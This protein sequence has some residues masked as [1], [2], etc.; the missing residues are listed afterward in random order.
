[1]AGTAAIIGS[2]IVGGASALALQ[3]AGF[4]VTLIDPMREPSG[5]SWGNAGHIATEQVE[6]L[7]SRAV[8]RSVPERL[9][10]NGGALDFRGRDIDRWLP[11]SLRW[12]AATSPARFAKGKAALSSL[13]ANA[14]AAWRRL[15]ADLGDA[16]L[17]R[18]IGHFVVWESERSFARGLALW[19]RADIGT[20][21]FQ[22][23]TPSEM[24]RI[25][26]VMAVKPAGAIRFENTGQISDHT[27]LA[28][29]LARTFES[30]GGNRRYHRADLARSADATRIL[31]DDGTSIEADVIVVAA[32]ARSGQVLA[33]EGTFAPIIAER[34]YHIRA[35]VSKKWP[36][37]L[38]PIAF[39]DRAVIAG[40]F[41]S[42]MRASSFVEFAR[43]D[44][45]PDPRKWERLRTHLVELGLPF[46][47][48][49]ERWM[50]SR[51]TLP[52]YLPAIGRSQ[53]SPNLF[54]AFGHQHLGLT[55]GPITGE[56][57]AQLVTGVSPAVP[58][59]PFSL[60]RFG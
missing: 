24:D 43:P 60:T 22:V 6:P 58:P 29:A 15:A 51:P 45:P 33:P 20:A 4:S 10:I 46:A 1:M 38:G 2:G 39:E 50:G 25:A 40:R 12:L 16:G 32:G 36:E 56:I 57:V 11:F 55:M 35:S 3:R 53:R 42:A 27:R 47:L 30:R 23:A 26:K 48:P 54:Y 18:E 49:G 34:G 31:L 37:D 17:Y 21:R 7:A 59:E 44:S 41:S 9:F 28:E 13:L 8:L 19:Q 5:A 52:D 14:A